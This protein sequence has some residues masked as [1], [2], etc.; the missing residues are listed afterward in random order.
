MIEGDDEAT[1]LLWTGGWDSTFRLL[2]LVLVQERRVQPYHL[3]DPNRKST[4]NELQAMST[5]RKALLEKHPGAVALLL[6]TTFQEVVR[7]PPD[8]ELTATYERLRKR[9]FLGAQYEWLA[10]FCADKGLRGLELCIVR[11]GEMRAILDPF[12]RF[13]GT[14]DDPYYEVDD[15]F[16]ESD[17][18]GLFQFFRFPT[19]DLAKRDMGRIAKQEAFGDLL[20]LTWFCLQPR[21]GSVPCG[22][23]HP[24]LFTAEEGLGRRIPLVNRMRYHLRVRSRVSELLVRIGRRAC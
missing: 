19:Y 24:C 7:I 2:H 5:I 8:G 10:R 17:E 18:Y 14:G 1:N 15:R 12:I 16:R 6:P 21:N 20:E 22:V 13:S 9:R 23:C 11:N 4:A 3:I